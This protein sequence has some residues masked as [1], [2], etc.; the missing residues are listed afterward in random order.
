[1]DSELGRYS[2]PE[3]VNH[4]PDGYLPV[5]ELP[6]YLFSLS[7]TLEFV[8]N[9]LITNYRVRATLFDR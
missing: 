2:V 9:Q 1:M 4:H 3:S 6:P 5:G 7:A 8:S